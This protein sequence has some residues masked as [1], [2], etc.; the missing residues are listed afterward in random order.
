MYKLTKQSLTEAGLL[1]DTCFTVE[2][3]KIVEHTLA[4]FAHYIEK[5]PRPLGIGSTYYVTSVTKDEE[6]VWVLAKWASR[7]VVVKEF[8]N[9]QEAFD[10]LE[11]TYIYDIMNNDEILICD[12]R[13]EAEDFLADLQS[14]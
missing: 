8:S 2:E 5:S 4:N 13:E 7:E 12:S 11:E 1:T 3:N 10:E 14:E 6:E 9:E